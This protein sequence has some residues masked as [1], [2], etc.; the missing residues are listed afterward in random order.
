[1]CDISLDISRDLFTRLK[2][3]QFFPFTPLCPCGDPPRNP[4][5]LSSAYRPL[6]Y[7]SLYN[8]KNTNFP[9][10]RCGERSLARGRAKMA[11]G[12][13][14]DCRLRLVASPNAQSLTDASSC[15]YDTHHTHIA[16][17]FRLIFDVQCD[18]S[19]LLGVTLSESAIRRFRIRLLY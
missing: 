3:P 2:R 15:H 13:H 18:G 8:R 17:V 5:A 19:V 10:S 6:I 11:D 16:H 12:F 14:F 1:M 9:N 4:R 7:C